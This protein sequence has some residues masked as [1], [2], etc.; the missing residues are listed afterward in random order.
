MNRSPSRRAKATGRWT[1]TASSSTSMKLQRPTLSWQITV[2]REGYY[3]ISWPSRCGGG[4]PSLR[5][6]V[7]LLGAGVLARAGQRLEDGQPLHGH[8][9]A[10]RAAVLG[11]L[12]HFVA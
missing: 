7:D 9:K 2:T 6:A 3:P 10:V 12:L 4:N 8:R 5:R 11:E 1:S